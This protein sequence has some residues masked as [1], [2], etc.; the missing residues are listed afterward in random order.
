M[1]PVRYSQAGPTST[2]SLKAFFQYESL[3]TE[4][5]GQVRLTM[6]MGAE[7]ELKMV[8]SIFLLGAIETDRRK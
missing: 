3:I 1:D 2:G 7:V 4:C 6:G 5:T 8:W